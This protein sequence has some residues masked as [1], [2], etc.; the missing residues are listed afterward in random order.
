M[1]GYKFCDD[2]K[3]KWRPILVKV[4]KGAKGKYD[5]KLQSCSLFAKNEKYNMPNK[6]SFQDAN[7]CNTEMLEYQTIFRNMSAVE[8]SKYTICMDTTDV[9]HLDIDWKEEKEY[10]DLSHD[11]VEDLLKI[12]PY[13]K[14]TTK[15]LG[16]HLF[17]KLDKKLT[18]QKTLLK[19]TPKCEVYEDLE[20]LSGNFG[21]CPAE[22]EIFN[23][24]L[25]MPTLKYEDLPLKFGAPYLGI[26]ANTGKLKMKLKKKKTKKEITELEE[27]DKDSKVFKY[28]DI[29]SVKH[30]DDY[31]TWLKLLTS[32]KS[33]SEKAVAHYI[34]QK[35]DKFK[36]A[37]FHNK[38]ESVD[39]TTISIGTMY[40]YAKISNNKAYRDLQNEDMDTM[41]FLDSD[42]TQA[43]L[44]LGNHE[45]NLVY[46]DNT[47]FM[48]IGN[49][50]GTEG[51][52]FKDEKNERV[53]KLLSDYLSG[54]Q[55]NRLSKLYEERKQIEEALEN[56]TDDADAVEEQ[57]TSLEEIGHKI[58][59]SSALAA[60]LKNCAKINTIAE[61][62]RSLL[63][64]VDYEEIQFDKNPYLLPFNN[65]CYDLKT[66]NWVGT[67]RE[68]YILETTGY[69][70]ITPNES[71]ITKISK[72]IDEIFP[73]PE[74][75]Q[76]YIHYLA[77]GLYGIPI[78][79]FI[80]AS[81]GGGNGKGVINELVLEVLGNFGYSANN[82]VLLNPL[83]EGGNPAIANM[84]GKRFINYR[85]PDEKKSLNLSAIKELTGG[86]G[87]CARKLYCNDD[88][89]ELVGTHVL[90]LNKKC[91]MVGDLGDSIMRRLR[92]IPFVATYTTDVELLKRKKE[93][94]NIFKANPYFKTIKLQNEFKYALFIY[95]IRYAKKWEKD[96]AGFNVCSRL[97]VASKIT[98]RTKHYIEDNDNI[99]MILKQHYIKD[100]SNKNNYVKFKEFW[101]FFKD[102]DFY[103][104]LSKH[105]QNKQYSEKNVVEHLK[106][107][108]STRI[109]FKDILNFKKPNGDIV[110][111]RN[112]LRYW[113]LKTT[114]EIIKEQL[115]QGGGDD[116]LEFEY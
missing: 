86:K 74:I 21:W 1:N 28:A 90:E 39:P 76:E 103:R 55:Q 58:K 111:Y 70:W 2:N 10:S 53:K 113:R 3:I 30:L 38:Y 72:L 23:A 44:F 97:F 56:P 49:E 63:S 59:F 101:C 79:K 112:V 69:N 4:S 29:I 19:L 98:D 52:W 108:T 25:K 42:D 7:F 50:E 114:D 91:P 68:N 41:E 5:K 80:F 33:A 110:S 106:T 77:T 64:V 88:K 57:K 47:I 32:L 60:K 11:F 61:R 36:E 92:D 12:C 34:S 26:D 89:V 66:H 48:Y 93:L 96:N 40:Y 54:L 85:E 94:N 67:R 62:L 87:I 20:I 35:S 46:L 95:L 100:M 37:D 81:G 43:K 75:R 109:F 83:K 17:F 15:A 27:L 107:S 78:E 99:F 45:N 22:N 65:T 84:S 24:D 14:S 9:Y 6:L 31:D 71:Q 102:S 8:Q 116:E 104:T 51:R 73:D 115:E 105:E 13:Y 16:K 82:A 18:K